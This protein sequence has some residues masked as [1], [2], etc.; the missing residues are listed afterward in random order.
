MSAKSKQAEDLLVGK[1]A[2]PVIERKE[3]SYTRVTVMGD[4]SDEV[5]AKADEEIARIEGEGHT[6]SRHMYIIV[7]PQPIAK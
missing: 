7:Y 6:I 5:I 2:E 1:L 4:N 3:F